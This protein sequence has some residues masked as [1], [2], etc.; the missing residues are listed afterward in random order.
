MNWKKDKNSDNPATLRG[1]GITIRKLNKLAHN[2][3][4]CFKDIMKNE[5]K[6]N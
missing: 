4:F 3:S 2:T 1:S 6:G 5:M